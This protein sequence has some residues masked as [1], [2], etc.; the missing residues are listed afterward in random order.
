MNILKNQLN[1]LTIYNNN[2]K[3]K[4][5][6]SKWKSYIEKKEIKEK[7]MK[8]QQKKIAKEKLRNIL[9]NLQKSFENFCCNC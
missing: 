5:Y 7:L 4:K 6:L 3:L 2:K 1:N 9:N 8:Y